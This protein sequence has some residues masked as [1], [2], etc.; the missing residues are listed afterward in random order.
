MSLR[1]TL[2]DLAEQLHCE[3][4][5]L[6]MLYLGKVEEVKQTYGLTAYI[7]Y[8]CVLPFTYITSLALHMKKRHGVDV[9]DHPIM[10]ELPKPNRFFCV[11]QNCGAAFSRVPLMTDHMRSAHV[12]V[13]YMCDSCEYHTLVHTHLAK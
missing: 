7:C 10:R 8:Q 11:E 13:R 1:V 4:Q 5:L 3:P 6:H 2:H 9:V 12:Q